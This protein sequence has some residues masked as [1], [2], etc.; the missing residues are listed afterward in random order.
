MSIFAILMPVQTYSYQFT[1]E[2]LARLEFLTDG[3]RFFHVET[4]EELQSHPDAAEVSVILT[5]WGAP[6]LTVGILMH[7]PS[8]R[9]IAHCAGTLRTIIDPT[10]FDHGVRATNSSV[11]NAV[12]V[13]EFLL[14]WVLRWNK[15]LPFCESSYSTSGYQIRRRSGMIDVLGNRDKTIGIISASKVGRKFAELLQHFELSVVIYDPFKS[16]DEIGSLGAQ[17]VDLQTLMAQSDIVSINA[18]MLPETRHMIGARELSLMRNGSLIINTARG[19]VMDHDSLLSELETGRISAVLDV[20]DPEPLPSESPF[21]KLP[22]VFLTPHVAG[23]LGSEIYR[24]TESAFDEVEGFMRDGTL[25]YEVS[26]ENW[27]SAA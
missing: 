20:T 19:G 13:A 14:S 1:A 3:G 16:E 15:Q 23:S 4:I 9:L 25:R 26:S 17:K 2:H 10:L 11:A 12:P 6:Q 8:L 18:P 7:C 24:L 21:F 27:M 22:N 5:G